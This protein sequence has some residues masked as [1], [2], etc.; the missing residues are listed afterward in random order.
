M[1]SRSSSVRRRTSAARDWRGD[2]APGDA[3]R[4]LA[5]DWR[6]AGLADLADWRLVDFAARAGRAREAVPFFFADFLGLD[7]FEPADL[8][9]EVD[10]RVARAGRFL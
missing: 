8:E 2:R 1:R 10:A 7:F 6:L 4:F 9:R 5:E 3:T